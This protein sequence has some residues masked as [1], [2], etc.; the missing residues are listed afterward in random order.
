MEVGKVYTG[1]FGTAAVHERLLRL[2]E[3]I[4][5]R[6][7]DPHSTRMGEPSNDNDTMLLGGQP[8]A[9]AVALQGFERLEVAAASARAV[10][11]G[12]LRRDVGALVDALRAERARSAQL[13]DDF[14]A[15]RSRWRREAKRL[16]RVVEELVAENDSL[17]ERL[18]AAVDEVRRLRKAAAAADAA[19]PEAAAGR[20]RSG[21]R[22]RA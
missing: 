4:A 10:A 21:R 2:P 17:A 20:R 1:T 6:D 5:R 8:A 19:A 7:T 16:A 15:A 12:L 14:A 9:L 11:D 13:A 3:F 18:E 22:R